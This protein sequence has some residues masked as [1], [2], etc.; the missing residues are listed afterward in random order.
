[1]A[2]DKKGTGLTIAITEISPMGN[3]MKG[4]KMM[5]QQDGKGK[6]FISDTLKVPYGASK[7][8]KMAMDEA[9]QDEGEGDEFSALFGSSG[10]GGEKD[11]M[12]LTLGEASVDDLK[13]AL[14]QKMKDDKVSAAPSED[15]GDMEPEDEDMA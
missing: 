8:E 14:A 4:H 3:N 9:A 15:E 6:K 5:G 11:P 12:K 10:N 2:N 13:A 1:M 7:G